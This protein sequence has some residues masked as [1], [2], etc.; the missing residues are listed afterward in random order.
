MEGQTLSLSLSPAVCGIL[1]YKLTKSVVTKIV[2][3]GIELMFF[4]FLRKSPESLRY[5][6]RK[7]ESQ[8]VILKVISKGGA[9]VC[10]LSK[11]RKE[12]L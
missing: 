2:S 4:I 9:I 12:K 8:K 1:G 6:D 7:S 5:Y 10:R 11:K 3:S